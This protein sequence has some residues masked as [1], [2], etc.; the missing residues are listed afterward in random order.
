MSGRRGT[1]SR[2]GRFLCAFVT[3]RQLPVATHEMAGIAVRKL[4]QIIL[5]FR[6]GLPEVAGRLDLGLAFGD[7]CVP[8]EGYPI[9]LFPPSGIVKAAAYESLN[10]EVLRLLGK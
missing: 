10:L 3:A 6:L 7:A 1:S 9:A 5:V 8:I 2:A 4:L